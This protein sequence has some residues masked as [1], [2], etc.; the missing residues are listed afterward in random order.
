MKAASGKMVAKPKKNPTTGS[1]SH[2]LLRKVR[3]I[4]AHRGIGKW[5]AL[6]KYGGPGIDKEYRR[7]LDEGT[8]ELGEAGA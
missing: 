5:E 6:D 4:S 3:L 7:C 1:M 2:E 8:R